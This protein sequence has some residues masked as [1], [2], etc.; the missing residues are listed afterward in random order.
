MGKALCRAFHWPFY[1]AGNFCRPQ[2]PVMLEEKLV[3]DLCGVLEHFQLPIHEATESTP[4]SPPSTEGGAIRHTLLKTLMALGLLM[5][6]R[7][8]RAKKDT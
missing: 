5:I 2:I 8:D 7:V 3:L 6:S 4:P 1:T